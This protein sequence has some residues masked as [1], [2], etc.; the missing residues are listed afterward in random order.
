MTDPPLD[1]AGYA[2]DA[3]SDQDRAE[4]EA[5]LAGCPHCQQTMRTS[6]DTTAQLSATTETE[7]PE[8]VRTAVL[9]AIAQPPSAQPGP[10]LSGGGHVQPARPGDPMAAAGP[11]RHHRQSR[12][13]RADSVAQRGNRVRWHRTGQIAAAA[14]ITAAQS[15]LL[16]TPDTEIYRQPMRD[17]ATISYVVSQRHNTAMAIVSGDP[18]PG[19]GHTF[20]LWTTH[21]PNGDKPR[22]DHTFTGNGSTPVWL[23]T[24][25]SSAEAVAVT[26]EP[27]GGTDHPTT[28]PFAAQKL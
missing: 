4:F 6:T 28:D 3:L 12:P 8:A 21:G 20:Q 15:R 25:I 2:L 5:H 24:N 23:K 18:E 22:P 9:A 17:G 19:A 11:G 26:V 16:A 14:A 10:E 27:A 7:P 13:G 1:V